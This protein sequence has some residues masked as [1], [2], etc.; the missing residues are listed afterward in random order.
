M[1]GL[2]LGAVDRGARYVCETY[3]GGCFLGEGRCSCVVSVAREE[4]QSGWWAEAVGVSMVMGVR[5][6]MRIGGDTVG[7]VAFHARGARHYGGWNGS[8]GRVGGR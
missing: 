5:G 4:M 8:V 2:G 1:W 3:L 6:P 7:L